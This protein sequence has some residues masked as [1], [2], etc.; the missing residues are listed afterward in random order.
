MDS[1]HRRACVTYVTTFVLLSAFFYYLMAD[2]SNNNKGITRLREDVDDIS[3]ML[4]E[5]QRQ[6]CSSN[7]QQSLN[8]FSCLAG[9]STNAAEAGKCE[10]SNAMNAYVDALVKRKIGNL[11]DDVYNLKKQIMGSGCG[12]YGG[13]ISSSKASEAVTTGKNRINYAAEELGARISKV[14]ARPIGGTNLFK[15]L[16]GLDFSSNP[17]VN[18]LRPSLAPGACFGYSGTKATAMLH[19]AKPI[20]VEAI[21]LTHVAKEMT[22]SLCVQSAPKDFEVHGIALSNQKPKLLGKWKY[23]NSPN[24]RTQSYTVHCKCFYRELEFIFN[25]NHGANM[26]CI[27]RDTS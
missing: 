18:M 9:D 11:M 13:G 2:N 12:F 19:L 1:S 27:Y 14:Q 3:H 16:L 6:G 22:P 21:A 10:D 15:S 5:Q 7:K 24:K 20:I 23:D 8:K 25:S 26:T 4:R 17:P